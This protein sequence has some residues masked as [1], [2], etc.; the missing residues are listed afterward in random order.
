MQHTLSEGRPEPAPL[1]GGWGERRVGCGRAQELQ[2]AQEL[3]QNISLYTPKHSKFKAAIES[4]WSW[5]VRS[6]HHL[7]VTGSRAKKT[8]CFQDNG[9]CYE[10]DVM[11][12]CLPIK[13]AP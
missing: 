4:V 11:V 3:F 6:P 1:S 5:A 8:S 10:P 13:R 9:S 2:G 7:T 12:I